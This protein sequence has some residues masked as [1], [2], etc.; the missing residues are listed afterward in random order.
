MKTN[1]FFT[2]IMLI[3]ACAMAIGFTSCRDDDDDNGSSSTYQ[4][5]YS[6]TWV[7]GNYSYN[8]GSAGKGFYHIGTST[9]ADFKYTIE[10]TSVTM[11]NFT[12]VNS[13][14]GDVWHE[15][16]IKHGSY[17]PDNDTFRADGKVY[18]RKK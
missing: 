12:Y 13:D 1:K 16:G 6:G 3:F 15:D 10:G 2:A 17:D 9:S 7:N 18:T 5:L 4:K 8:F 11:T 14:Y